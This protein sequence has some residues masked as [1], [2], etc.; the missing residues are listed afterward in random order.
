MQGLSRRGLHRTALEV[1][2]LLL[3][4][5]AD[6]PLG[7]LCTVDYLALRAGR[8][9]REGGLVW[10]ARGGSNLNLNGSQWVHCLA[11][12]QTNTLSRHLA[13]CADAPPAPAP[14]PHPCRYDFLYRL[15]EQ[16]GGDSSAALLPN[17][18]YSQAL[19]RWFQEQ[20]EP[21]VT[22]GTAGGL[23]RLAAAVG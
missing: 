12:V 4:L 5:N 15:A 7:A 11:G 3:A 2:K 21:L 10:A 19:A 20:G 22:A 16:Y 13:S 8:W 14:A 18:V 1:C 23:C 17:F 6:D 9:V